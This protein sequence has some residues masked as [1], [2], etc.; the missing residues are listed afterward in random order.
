MKRFIVSVLALSM[1]TL[2]LVACSG[3]SNESEKPL[4]VENEV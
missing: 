2:S 3:K 1:L 4:E